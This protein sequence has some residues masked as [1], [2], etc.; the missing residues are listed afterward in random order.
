M[1]DNSA[2]YFRS[3]QLLSTELPDKEILS[4]S[5]SEV[6]N[7]VKAIYSTIHDHMVS[8]EITIDEPQNTEVSIQRFDKK[9]GRKDG[10]I[11]L[12][13]PVFLCVI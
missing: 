5:L 9:S 1:F 13:R 2:R 8:A 7:R 11:S 12:T 3:L 6:E 10:K 4:N